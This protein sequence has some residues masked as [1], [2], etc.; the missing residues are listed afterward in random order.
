MAAY[1]TRRVLVAVVQIFVVATLVF[2]FLHLLPGDPVMIILGSERSIQPEQVAAVRRSLGLDQPLPVQYGTWVQ[3]LVR[4][5]L[6]TS[7]VDN[8]PVG[9]SIGER[10]PRSLE[11]VF[12]ATVL[13]VVVA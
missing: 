6:G 4:L 1:V 8:T 2:A 12:A 11:L 9:E 7:L 10:F 3:Q 5:D 13:A